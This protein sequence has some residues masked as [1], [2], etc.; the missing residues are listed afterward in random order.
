MFGLFRQSKGIVLRR[1]AG[2]WH[3]YVISAFAGVPADWRFAVGTDGADI[4][5]TIS[6]P[7]S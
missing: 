2:D 5:V 1:R 4:E 7:L 3:V 6:A